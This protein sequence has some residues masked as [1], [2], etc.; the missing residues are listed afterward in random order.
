MSHKKTYKEYTLWLRK[1]RDLDLITLY[2]NDKRF[3]KKV[4]QVLSDFANGI[5]P[6]YS[7][8]NVSIAYDDRLKDESLTYP[9][10]YMKI[11]VNPKKYPEIIEMLDNIRYRHRGDFIKCIIKNSL[12]YPICNMYFKE[13]KEVDLAYNGSVDTDTKGNMADVEKTEKTKKQADRKIPEQYKQ[14]ETLEVLE[15]I[16]NTRDEVQKQENN[17][18]HEDNNYIDMLSGIIEDF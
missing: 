17:V 2:L 1:I 10:Q 14:T 5:K 3:K 11:I 6:N 13:F 8:E 7:L 4:I 12:P 9:T 16:E 15:K 18:Q